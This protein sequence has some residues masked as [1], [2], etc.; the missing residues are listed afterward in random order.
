MCDIAAHLC[1][2]VLPD[3]PYRQWVLSL[4]VRVRY[5]V[6]RHRELVPKILAV[7]LRVI[8]AHQRRQARELGIDGALSGALSFE[9]RF[10]DGARCHFHIHTVIPD[11]IF[12]DPEPGG[13]AVFVPLPAPH[14]D[15][16][17]R[18]VVRIRVRVLRLLRRAGLDPE[19]VEEQDAQGDL[20]SQWQA[21]SLQGRIAVGQRAG[22]RVV[23]V[24][25]QPV[26]VPPLGKGLCADVDGY[27]LHAGVHVAAGQ[28]P[29]LESL[30]RYMLRPP[31]A[32][33]RLE[34]L[35][36]GGVRI[37][38]KRPYFGRDLRAGL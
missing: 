21:A 29:R 10:G 30:V 4:P 26:A 20:L 7:F 32:K 24:G 35:E 27:N 12:H 28:R 13:P 34:R 8:F 11:G 33:D 38:L 36:D 9:Q 31:F 17:A 16:L 18:I 37:W 23:R 19:Q 14:R 22:W 15:E 2:R 5:L 1:A 3:V 25:A 6:L